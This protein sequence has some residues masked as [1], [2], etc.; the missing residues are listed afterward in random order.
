[1]GPGPVSCG[2]QGPACAGSLRFVWVKDMQETVLE[3]PRFL[4][5][6]SVGSRKGPSPAAFTRTHPGSNLQPRHVPD[7]ESNLQPLV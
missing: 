6:L 1:M 7:W 3:S 5:S 2:P 4:P